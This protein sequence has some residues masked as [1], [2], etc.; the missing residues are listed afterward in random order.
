MNEDQVRRKTIARLLL[1]ALFSAAR[2]ASGS[3]EAALHASG[4]SDAAHFLD[5]A[6][7]RGIKVEEIE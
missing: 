3:R 6:E 5:E 2:I 1:A 7:R 4:F